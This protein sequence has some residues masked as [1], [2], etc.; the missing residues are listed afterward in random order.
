VLNMAAGEDMRYHIIF[1]GVDIDKTKVTFADPVFVDYTKRLIR[2]Y[3]NMDC[4]TEEHTA[5]SGTHKFLHASHLK[6]KYFI[7][8]TITGQITV[9]AVNG[10]SIMERYRVTVC[11]VNGNTTDEE[12]LFTTG[13]VDTNDTL[14]WHTSPDYG[15]ERVYYFE[16]DAWEKE[17]LEEFD[18]I[19][20]KVE[21]DAGIYVVFFHSN[22]S[23]WEDLK[24]DIPFIL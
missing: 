24:V 7:E 20:F 8:G 23:T 12:E 3:I 10:T 14:T 13:W 16:I 4:A 19:Y 6:K 1:Y 18:R 2:D 11:K 5:A 21:I 9:G 15:D 22:D 17:T